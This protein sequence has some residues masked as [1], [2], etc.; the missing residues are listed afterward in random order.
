MFA[1][2]FLFLYAQYSNECIVIPNYLSIRLFRT[3]DTITAL[4][5]RSNASNTQI[6]EIPPHIIY[7]WY[8]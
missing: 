1:F 2:L 4:H 6:M 8:L 5:V 3:L 7:Y